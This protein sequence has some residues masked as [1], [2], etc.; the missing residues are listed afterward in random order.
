MNDEK[1]Q[2]KLEETIM[3]RGWKEYEMETEGMLIRLPREVGEI[4]EEGHALHHCVAGYIDRMI[5]GKTCILF[6]RRKEAPE[7]QYY[8]IEV[9]EGKIMQCRG[10]NNREMTTEVKEF[11]SLFEKKKLSKAMERKAG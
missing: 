2:E 8:T 1:K 9:K 7:K 5:E 6:I 10:K 11:V 4:R 3:R